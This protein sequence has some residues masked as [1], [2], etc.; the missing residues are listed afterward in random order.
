MV[1]LMLLWFA[2]LSYRAVK[3]MG[4]VEY[5]VSNSIGQNFSETWIDN[6]GK[7]NIFDRDKNLVAQTFFEESDGVFSERSSQPF[8]EEI[9]IRFPKNPTRPEEGFVKGEVFLLVNWGKFSSKSE[10]VLVSSIRP[11]DGRV[12][13][14]TSYSLDGKEI[15]LSTRLFNNKEKSNYYFPDERIDQIFVSGK[16]VSAVRFKAKGRHFLPIEYKH[17]F[18]L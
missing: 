11:L 16:V 7:I 5:D 1:A 17:T 9:L 8:Q 18:M 4:V 15:I 12:V 3:E 13:S 10:A 2:A 6:N 14:V